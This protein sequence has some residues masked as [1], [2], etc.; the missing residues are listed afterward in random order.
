MPKRRKPKEAPKLIRA[1]VASTG[2][3]QKQTATSI[4]LSAM[5]LNHLV[6][7]YRT[8]SPNTIDTMAV[9]LNLTPVQT[10]QL[11]QAAARDHGFKI[12]LKDDK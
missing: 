5:Y 11:H 6:T 9:A 3:S 7:G 4:G 10:V 1:I 8:P 2:M 12:D